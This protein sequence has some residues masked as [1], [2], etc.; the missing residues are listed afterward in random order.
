MKGNRC[1]TSQNSKIFRLRRA[2]RKKNVP[3]HWFSILSLKN[4]YSWKSNKKY[5]GH[6]PDHWPFACELHSQN[7]T[8]RFVSFF[9]SLHF[10]KYRTGLEINAGRLVLSAVGTWNDHKQIWNTDRV[11][12]LKFISKYFEIFISL[13]FVMNMEPRNGCCK[14]RMRPCTLGIV[15]VAII[16]S[17]LIV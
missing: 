11:M 8:F 15:A 4:C 10:L 13:C 16:R 6:I 12:P 14:C 2:K 5:T 7:R 9:K 1:K 17:S 3:K